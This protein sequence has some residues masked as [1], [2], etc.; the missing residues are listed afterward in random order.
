MVQ[1][2]L[3]VANGIRL[4][5]GLYP[6]WGRQ[7]PY[8]MMKVS[9]GHAITSWSPLKAELTDFTVRQLRDHR[10]NDLSPS[11]RNEGRLW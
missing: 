11:P 8:T 7:I 2:L 5:K 6:L 4:Y 3:Y 10:G 9:R 1:L